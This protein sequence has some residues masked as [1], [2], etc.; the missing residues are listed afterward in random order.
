[1][2]QKV[3]DFLTAHNMDTA[4]FSFAQLVDEYIEEMTRGLV[5]EDSSLQMEPSYVCLGAVK[6]NTPVCVIDAGGTNLRIASAQFDDAGAFTF[7][8]QPD[9][10][11]MLGSK[12]P[13]TAEEFFRTL[14]QMMLPHMQHTSHAVLSFAFPA[15]NLPNLDARV[16]FLDKEVVVHGINGMLLA[17]NLEKALAEQGVRDPKVIVINDSVATCLSGMAERL[18]D[19]FD[20]YTGT[21][22]G[23]GNNSCYVEQI[24]NIK[25]IPPA[26]GE[27]I[28]N[29]EA[30]GFAKAPKSDIDLAFDAGLHDPG[31]QTGEKQVS[32]AYLGPLCAFTLQT[33][34]KEG[35]FTQTGDLS[36]ISTLDVDN[37][38]R[39]RSGALAEVCAADELDCVYE[40]VCAVVARAALFAAVQM[41]AIAKK[42]GAKRVCMTVEG[43]TYYKLYQF[44]QRIDDTIHAY[45]KPLGI[46]AEMIEVDAAVLKGCAIAGLME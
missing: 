35:V 44:K 9:K 12:T 24:K 29:T 13:I 46:E 7:L 3:Q 8:T 14:A 25:K 17:E 31:K 41:A 23:T 34:A 37:F 10:T 27:M 39:S 21:I 19:G 6:K 22:L 2:Q 20:T 28:I 1:M 33:A 16:I 30:G 15:Q 45:F 42:A 32:G 11:D 38:L 43:S 40:I 26:D 4:R 18:A 36:A 5:G